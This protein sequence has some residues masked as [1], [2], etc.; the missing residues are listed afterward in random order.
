[1]NT[2][3]FWSWFSS[4]SDLLHSSNA[5][6]AVERIHERVASYDNRLGVEISDN[7]SEHELVITAYG[8]PEAFETAEKL[9][10]E[11]PVCEGWKFTALKQ[12]G[13]FDFILT[14][15][16]LSLDA[17]TLTFEPLEASQRPY[18]LG[19]RVYLPELKNIPEAFEDVIR[20]AIQ[21]GV[22]EKA[23]AAVKHVEVA[24][25]ADTTNDALPIQ[26]LKRYIEWH[27]KR[28]SA[29]PEAEKFD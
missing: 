15:D 5:D 27:L 14:H 10:G 18:E 29:I 6:A 11:A 2:H 26:D 24:P 25:H 28:Y 16:D 8:N 19:I 22:G 3:E 7:S 20:L 21:T 12:P 1:M 17:A 13:G 9:I 23:A 4:N